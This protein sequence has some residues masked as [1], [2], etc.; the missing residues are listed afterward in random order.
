MVV[1]E[2]REAMRKAESIEA[3]IGFG[4]KRLHAQKQTEIHREHL[5]E[6]RGKM[7]RRRAEA[8]QFARE[9]DHLS[10]AVKYKIGERRQQALDLR[11]DIAGLHC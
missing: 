11:K 2:E 4:A 5:H 8:H 10:L 6:T 1:E 7:E 3:Q 9:I